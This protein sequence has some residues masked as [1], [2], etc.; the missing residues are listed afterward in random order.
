MSSI[1]DTLI[2]IC[3]EIIEQNNNPYKE[4]KGISNHIFDEKGIQMYVG[5]ELTKKLGLYV[6]S[7]D[8]EHKLNLQFERKIINKVRGKK[9]YLDIFLLHKDKRIGIE[10]KFKTKGI[11]IPK[12]L[13][14]KSITDE[15]E[16]QKRREKFQYHFSNQG[17]ETNGHHS[18]FWDLHR[19][20][21]FINKKEIELGYQRFITN[22]PSYWKKKKEGSSKGYI[23]VNKGLK[24]S[25]KKEPNNSHKF[26]MSHETSIDKK[27]E[28]PNWTSVDGIEGQKKGPRTLYEN[29]KK[30]LET[31][32]YGGRKE[33]KLYCQTDIDLE[34]VVDDKIE[35]LPQKIKHLGEEHDNPARSEE[36]KNKKFNL[37]A[38][39]EKHAI[40][41]FAFVIVELEKK[42]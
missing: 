39:D 26:Q 32:D 6:S 3:E 17:A 8:K 38:D 15:I 19:L 28:A 29:L 16:T 37:E 40:T 13:G 21:D 12:K 5:W 42:S 2:E 36:E 24:I 33:K 20:N 7:N 10:L 31:K 1:R 35:W 18:F 14:E 22:D 23:I 30:K 4:H 34:H 27:M 25:E 9:D 41:K 11:R